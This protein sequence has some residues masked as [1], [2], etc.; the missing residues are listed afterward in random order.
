MFTDRYA[1]MSLPLVVAATWVCIRDRRLLVVRPGGQDAFYLPGGTP[2]SGESLA[3]TTVR[4][5]AEETGIQLRPDDL[6]PLL[7][8]VAPAHGRP[9]VNVRLV[10]FTASSDG[11][12]I[13]AAEIDEVAWFTAADAA[14]CAPAVREVIGRLVSDGVM[15]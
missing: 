7:E 10:C 4:E 13:A 12:P 11:E 5:V 15:A 1:A 14:R 3:Q 6:R 8:V 2:E 9:G